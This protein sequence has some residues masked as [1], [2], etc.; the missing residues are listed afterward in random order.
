M[1]I[2]A[3][4]KIL[5]LSATGALLLYSLLGF[6]ILPA[7]LYK[8]IPKVAQEKLNRDMQIADI[9]FNP[10]SME[11]NVH[12]FD[13]KNLDGSSFAN[14]E[15]LYIDLAVLQSIVS[16]TLTM[17]QVMLKQP[18][19]L[20]KR[21]KQANFNFTDL[22]DNQAPESKKKPEEDEIF[23][24]IISK[25]TITDGKLS[26]KD[27][28][29]SQFQH[30]DIYPLNLNINNFTTLANKQS[31]LGFSLMLASG[32]QLEW[33]GKLELNPFYSQGQI[34][35]DKVKFHKVWELFLQDS[36]N[37]KLLTGSE[38]IEAEYSLT[39]S[40]DGMQ[41]LV[42]NAHIDLYDITLSEKENSE[43]IISVPEFKVSGISFDLLKKRIEISKVSANNPRLKSW[44][45]A[46][47]SINYQSLFAAKSIANKQPQQSQTPSREKSKPWNVAVNQLAINNL[48]F[49]FT[50]K[51]LT[52]PAQINLTSLNLKSTGLTNKPGAT[53]PI[54]LGL[55]FNNTGGIK[56]TGHA[57]LE[58]FSS[59]IKID[60]KDIS[61]KNFQ[62][63]I[64]KFARLDV[65]S[66]LFNVNANI[67]FLQADH[68]ALAIRIKGDSH[69]NN[70]VSRDQISN[71]DFLNWKQLNLNTIDLDLANNNYTVDQVKIE[72]P[73]TTIL[74]RKNKTINVNDIAISA[75]QKE[76]TPL[77]NKQTA[78]P[79][80]GK[81][82]SKPIFKITDFEMVEGV[83]DFSDKSLILPFSAHINHLKGSVEGISSDKNAVIKTTLN[84]RVAEMSPVIIKGE[85]SP[86]LG[87][88]EFKLDFKSMSLPLMTPYMVEFAGRKIEKGN[89]SLGLQ[90]KIINNQL[91]ASNNLL[92]DQ[93][94]LGDKVE[95]PKAVSLPLNFAIALLEDS[96]GKILLEVPITGN[97]DSPEF[98]VARVIMDALVNVISKIVSS[99]F[100]A[101]ASLIGS[102][103]DISKI[104][105]LP[106]KALLDNKQK[107]KL[108]GLV[109]ALSNRPAL[110]L[111]IKGTA[112]SKSDW[113]HLQTEALDN[114]LLQIQADELNKNSD[115]KNILPEYIKLSDE[116]YQRLLAD[117]FIKKFPDLAERSLFGTPRLLDPA[118]GDFYRVARSKLSK[119]IPP[120]TQRLNTLAI[121]RAQAI[122]KYL[123]NKNIAVERVFLLDIDVD[124][125]DSEQTMA[126][127][128][129]L[130]TD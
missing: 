83:L 28:Y 122:A 33:T 119:L 21:D 16:F 107:E 38:L 42:N 12:G 57:V 120:D 75:G 97:L 36:V 25:I 52:T 4:L 115:K 79:E 58:P 26:W 14:F 22:L 67:S 81:V 76:K 125:E 70:F 50:D 8:Q 30:E 127:R 72:H 56:I 32:G 51:S 92:I 101:I 118:M 19:V 44:L 85:I 10:F 98:S 117:L 111:E 110:K 116:E 7:V 112:Y 41:F 63:Y 60:A 90:Y 15:Q 31:Q 99:P 17:D 45:N 48:A 71:K 68:E 20:V 91:T 23:P 87:N 46:D 47:G 88:S 121:D 2:P 109:N 53:L 78:P 29:Y 128:L 86:Y 124:P 55:T 6:L 93:L 24:V 74:I 62:P 108:N 123:L 89:M 1:A 129:S 64:D 40:R 49:N 5:L 66:G 95:N 130:T 103:E 73:Y 59:Q 96:N 69:I 43:S 35:L 61:L 126:T 9:K 106:G 113:P 105:F 37:F 11:L 3:K 82:N 34:K 80:V 13:V 65:I 27:N 77:Q 39:D 114:Q 104:T 102:D 84:G 18:Y 54:D 100:Y 94:V